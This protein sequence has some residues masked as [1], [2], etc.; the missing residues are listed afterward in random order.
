MQKELSGKQS[1]SNNNASDGGRQVLNDAEEA[2]FNNSSDVDAASC[3]SVARID[4][5]SAETSC[6]SSHR[7]SNLDLSQDLNFKYLK[8]V[9][10]K[11]FLSREHEVS[12]DDLLL[13]FVP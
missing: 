5:S 12:A 8:H 3:D 6:Y 1:N 13:G 4:V 7:M 2:F 10:L 11:F 9:I